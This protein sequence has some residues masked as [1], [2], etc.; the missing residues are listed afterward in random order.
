MALDRKSL[1]KCQKLNLLSPLIN[2]PNFL[3]KFWLK[4]LSQEDFFKDHIE[5]FKQLIAK[6]QNNYDLIIA[7]ANMLEGM[8]IL[9]KINRRKNWNSQFFDRN[10]GSPLHL[11]IALIRFKEDLPQIK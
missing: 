7:M 11:A 10:S 6:L 9:S 2:Q 5:A 4:K 3:L 8:C 1:K